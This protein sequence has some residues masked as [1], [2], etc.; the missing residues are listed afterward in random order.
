MIVRKQGTLLCRIASHQDGR[1][2]GSV[3][4]CEAWPR[5]TD[6]RRCG[7]RRRGRCIAFGCAS[8]AQRW[9]ACRARGPRAQFE[10]RVLNQASRRGQNVVHGL[11]RNQLPIL[12]HTGRNRD[13]S[14]WEEGARTRARMTTSWWNGPRM[15]GPPGSRKA[16]PPLRRPADPSRSRI[17]IDQRSPPES[18]TEHRV[19][20]IPAKASVEVP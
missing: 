1:R 18:A 7:W 20:P 17:P 10:G 2:R 14:P 8:R 13:K 9:R 11:G 15:T 3:A 12:N 19:H 16:G 6:R 5:P 4:R